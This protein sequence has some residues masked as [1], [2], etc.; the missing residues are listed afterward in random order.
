MANPFP[1]NP[2]LG[3]TAFGEKDQHRFFGRTSETRELGSLIIARRAVLLYAQSGAGKTSLLQASLLPELQRR[4]RISAFPIARVTG[5]SITSYID[6]ALDSLLPGTP[7]GLSFTDAFRS[8]L[9]TTSSRPQPHLIVF[10]Q[11]EEI[12]T[13]HPELTKPRRRFF[14]QL[15]DCLAAYPQLSL[16]ISMREDYLADL[17]DYASLLPDRMRTRMRLERLTVASAKEAIEQPATDAG[18]PF[19]DTA[20]LNLIDNLRFSKEG[21]LGTHVEPVQLQIVCRQLWSSLEKVNYIKPAI[22]PEAVEEYANVNNVLTQFYRDALAKATV[23]GVTERQL[24]N[25]FD[26]ALITSAKTRGFVICTDDGAAGLPIVALKALKATSIVRTDLHGDNIYCELSHDR[27]V[28][29]ILED[30]QTWLAGYHNPVA[31]AFAQY[32]LAGS[33]T[34]ALITGSLLQD[35]KQFAAEHPSEVELPERKFLDQSEQAERAARTRRNWAILTA[36][37]VIAIL[38]AATVYSYNKAVIANEA[39]AQLSTQ[40]AALA[41]SIDDTEQAKKLA[42]HQEREARARALSAYAVQSLSEDPERAV[43]LA[44]YAVQ[45]AFDLSTPT[46]YIAQEALHNSLLVSPLRFSVQHAKQGS[47]MV[48]Y[49]PNG[50]G[51]ATA[52]WYG[53]IHIWSPTGKLIRKIQSRE[54]IGGIEY[55]GNNILAVAAYELLLTYNLAKPYQPVVLNPGNQSRIRKMKFNGSGTQV[56][57]VYDATPTELLLFNRG[58]GNRLVP[59]PTPN[60]RLNSPVQAMDFSPAGRR[61]AIVT[62]DHHLQVWDIGQAVMLHDKEAHIYS[63]LSVRF[64]PGSEDEVATSSDEPIIRLWRVGERE[65]IRQFFGP[66][67]SVFELVFTPDGK[68]MVSSGRDNVIRSWDVDRGVEKVAF[69]GS[70]VGN[71]IAMSPNGRGV[72]SGADDGSASFWSMVPG[73]ELMTLSTSSISIGS[74][75][76][77]SAA[78]NGGISLFDLSTQTLLRQVIAPGG[79]YKAALNSTGDWLAVASPSR[80]RLYKTD[81]KEV[82]IPQVIGAEQFAF[83]PKE[84][85]LAVLNNASIQLLNLGDVAVKLGHRFK[86]PTPLT[87]N[88]MAFSPD[89]RTLAVPTFAE[90]LH[91]YNTRAG[92]ILPPL[93]PKAG[94]LSGASFNKAGSRLAF[95]NWNSLPQILN[96][97]DWKKVRELKGHVGYVHDL[98]F[99]PD[100]EVIATASD[101]RTAKLWDAD[102]GRQ[103]MS[104]SLPDSPVQEIFFSPDGN[105]LAVRSQ[106]DVA[107]VF[108]MDP[109]KLL[110]FS[111][112]RTTRSLTAEECDRYFQT[113]S[114][115]PIP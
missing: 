13:F 96:T 71:R 52:D 83:D 31:K 51:F 60:L 108:W 113:T 107:R 54:G 6:N 62:E 109:Q 84:D 94:Y 75:H 86:R 63:V 79:A 16:L 91:I 90:N 101:D 11:F 34:E 4:K 69:R 74:N 89:G 40:N 57:I 68:Q 61:I 67:L 53:A 114:C 36:V 3:P 97:A 59:V 2:Y 35:C 100:G 85:Q 27:L 81:G 19:E 98:V 102:S 44:R 5:D 45:N 80:V 104:I 47:V 58:A 115:P 14:T 48:A 56:A 30:N 22:T 87:I 32:Q 43:I 39:S 49:D 29:P 42:L 111:R 105:Y 24:R 88:S 92:T 33:R 26:N 25:W 20:T 38:G 73:E 18:L 112:S 65:A 82:P 76:R 70:R 110:Q 64:R 21:E 8:V 72:V 9:D 55:I 46:L 106:N 41:K 37:A 99:S 103:L 12:F 7:A 95:G 17:E 50:D 1:P 15:S 28:Q 10:D 23:P 77:L 78:I 66:N 93:Q